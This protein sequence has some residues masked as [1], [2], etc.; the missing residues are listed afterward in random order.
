MI[1]VIMGRPGQGKTLYGVDRVFD[2]LSDKKTFV[3]SNI[4]IVFDPKDKRKDRYMQLSVSTTIQDILSL[5]LDKIFDGM[6]MRRILL[7]IDE[8]QT[9]MNSRRW[10]E[11]PPEFEFFLQ[12]H[13]HYHIDIIG[14]T[15]SVKRADPVMREL[16]QFFY[17]IEKIFT[18][19]TKWG[20]FGF[21]LRWQYDPDSIESPT[22][23]YDK[24]D[25]GF[26]LLVFASPFVCRMYDTYQKFP[27]ISRTG[28]KEVYEYLLQEKTVVDKVLVSRKVMS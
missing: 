11:L 17:K 12:Q 24:L 18:V 25:L 23:T 14:L 7:V 9:I 6:K 10:A 20:S 16:I 5:P 19:R 22:R 13:R 3:C 26:P 1:T 8:C 21:F 28:Q 2:G 27:I 15:Q 4:D